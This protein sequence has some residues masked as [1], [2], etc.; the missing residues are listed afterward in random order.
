MKKEIKS[1]WNWK[2]MLE[3]DHWPQENSKTKLCRSKDKLLKFMSSDKKKI[4]RCSKLNHSSWK[5]RERDRTVS[6]L[7]AAHSPAIACWNFRLTSRWLFLQN[8]SAKD[9]QSPG[10][11]AC[12]LHMGFSDG[13]LPIINLQEWTFLYVD[14]GV[15]PEL[16]LP[17][18]LPLLCP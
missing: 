7:I 3:N 11:S 6:L 2:K 4:L 17:H 13:W 18:F 5:V 8:I 16:A 10:C 12:C 1:V 14:S 15:I 9:R